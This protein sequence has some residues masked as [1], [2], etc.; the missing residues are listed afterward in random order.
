M[1]KF[2][3]KKV[4]EFA[5]A[6]S[7]LVGEIEELLEDYECDGELTDSQLNGIRKRI[8]ILK[9]NEKDFK[10]VLGIEVEE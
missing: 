10:K 8:R 5:I 6:T 9:E 3:R 4:L 2:E 1:D 7:F